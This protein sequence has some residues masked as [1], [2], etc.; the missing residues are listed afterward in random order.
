MTQTGSNVESLIIN[1]VVANRDLTECGL[2][3][4]TSLAKNLIVCTCVCVCVGER[5]KK[6]MPLFYLAINGSV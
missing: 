4:T 6:K 3:D 1:R 5:D 2:H